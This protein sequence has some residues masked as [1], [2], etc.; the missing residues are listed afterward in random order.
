MKSI[1]QKIKH[2]HYERL[3]LLITFYFPLCVSVF[4]ILILPV[5]PSCDGAAH[6][7]N[8]KIIKELLFNSSTPFAD[9]YTFNA[10]P[11]PNWLDHIF[12]VILLFL[13]S[14]VLAQK[15]FLILMVTT[16]AML[17]YKI[18]TKLKP[19][20][21]LLSV[22]VLPFIFSSFFYVGLYN[23]QLSFVALYGFIYWLIR[24][25]PYTQS[26][27]LYY[28]GLF[29]FSL[30][31]WLS[32]IVTYAIFLLIVGVLF[33]LKSHSD[34]ISIS[35]CFKEMCKLFLVFIPTLILSANFIFKINM[36]TDEKPIELFDKTI[37]FFRLQPLMTFDTAGESRFT[38]ALVIILLTLALTGLKKSKEDNSVLKAIKICSV[39][40]LL[41]FFIVPNEAGAG[42]LS[43]RFSMSFYLLAIISLVLLNINRRVVLVASVLICSIQ[44]GL[45]FKR[46]NGN[47][48]DKAIVENN[49]SDIG[50]HIPKGATVWP[51]SLHQDW[52]LGHSNNYAGIESSAIIL[53]NY[54]TYYPWFPL[55]FKPSA[56]KANQFYNQLRIEKLLSQNTNIP[57]DYALLSGLDKE[58]TFKN[59]K[60]YL[61][62]KKSA[63]MV[64]QTADSSMKL[65][66]I[67]FP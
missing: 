42:M 1:I 13:F 58:D 55:S 44:L 20:N 17:F 51:V 9:F 24:S 41:A 66:K 36:A 6:L 64:F 19:E 67:N 50:L 45:S 63:R 34:R 54:E 14:P 52:F 12:L 3:G 62:L 4:F 10:I 60:L 65:Y 43:Y 48:K 33:L 57:A 59:N 30:I 39:I 21:K 15:I 11:V 31:F 40:L 47:M 18:V 29:I 26:G 2:G 37:L 61:H 23:Q 56:K 8:S 5:Y 32:S 27:F 25:Q 38:I 46:H 16:Q 7:Y 28:A 35:R 49:F 53:E 22:L